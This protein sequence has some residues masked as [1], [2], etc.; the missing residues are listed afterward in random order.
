MVL[1]ASVARADFDEIYPVV[2]CY[3]MEGNTRIFSSQ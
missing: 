1:K 2:F 3:H